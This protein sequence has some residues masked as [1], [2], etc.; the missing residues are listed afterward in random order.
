V[1]DPI[2]REL[3]AGFAGKYYVVV[4]E[5][6]ARGYKVWISLAKPLSEGQ[7]RAALGLDTRTP[8]PADIIRPGP[9]DLASLRWIAHDIWQ[10]YA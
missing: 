7:L 9:P 10:P 6:I 1:V 5:F 2:S 8:Y 3:I 4:V